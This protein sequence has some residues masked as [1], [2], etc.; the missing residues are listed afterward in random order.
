MDANVA[1]G[2]GLTVGV[3]AG[4][5]GIG[6]GIAVNGALGG[7]AR[8]PD[9]SRFISTQMLIGLAFPELCFLLSFLIGFL[10]LSKVSTPAAGTSSM[11]SPAQSAPS[12]R[13]IA[14]S[15]ALN[16]GSGKFVV[17]A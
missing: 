9:L 4:G 14:K 2:I 17:F 6:Q 8:Q 15:V 1:I 12:G 7:M 10:L 3:A 11:L 13:P 5:V 16:D